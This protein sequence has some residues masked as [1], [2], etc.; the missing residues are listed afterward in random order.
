M[1]TNYS[2][3]NLFGRLEYENQYGAIKDIDF[4]SILES[5]IREGGNNDN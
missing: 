4:S 2:Y 1:D 3:T 5:I